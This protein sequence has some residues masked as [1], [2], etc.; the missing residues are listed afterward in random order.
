[1]FSEADISLFRNADLKRFT[2]WDQPRYPK[3]LRD[4]PL[5]ARTPAFILR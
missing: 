5:D 3:E 2:R 1:M 4:H